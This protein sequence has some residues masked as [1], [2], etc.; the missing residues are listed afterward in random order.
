MIIGDTSLKHLIDY[1]PRQ[2]YGVM[3]A[4]Q[5]NEIISVIAGVT[6][7]NDDSLLLQFPKVNP[8]HINQKITIHLDNRTGIEI[9]THEFR[10]YRCSYKG[11]VVSEERD[12][13][14]KVIPEE[15]TL[16]YANNTVIEYRNPQYQYPN[17]LREKIKPEVSRITEDILPDLNEQENKLGI[18]I[19]KAIDR[20]HTTVM[21]FLSSKN[22]DIFLISH[23]GAFKSSLIHKDSNCVFA[24]DHRAS[25]HFE[26]KYEWNYTL[27]KADARIVERSD[28]RFMEI[29]TMFVDKN[30]WELMFFTDPQVE[31][32]HLEPIEIICPEKYS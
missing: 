23:K 4:Y 2:T 1:L 3:C 9:Y 30:P 22:D 5:E 6:I 31:M 18:W 24:I 13:Q 25:Y 11:I 8:F 16:Q 28:K 20:P 15:F 14:I 12:S 27:I 29:Q 10:V 7:C 17:D 26:K 21:A 19:T 32:F